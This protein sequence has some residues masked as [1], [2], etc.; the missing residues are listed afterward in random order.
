MIYKWKFKTAITAIIFCVLVIPFACE[1]QAQEPD[2][3]GQSLLPAEGEDSV[4]V[5]ETNDP[6]LNRQTYLRQIGAT[7]AWKEIN[8][9]EEIV[10]AVVDTGVD[11]D[12]PDLEGNLV[13]GINLIERDKPPHDDN[14]HGTN[15]A[16]VIA[17]VGNNGMGTSGVLWKGKIM[18]I[19]ALES[20]GRGDEEK[21]AE[22][23]RYAVDHGAKIVVLSVGLLRNDPKVEQTIR[24][25][26]ER[27]VLLI[28][29]AGND[30]GKHIRFPG[31]YPTVMAIGGVLDGNEVQERSNYG[32]ELDLVASWS[33]FTTEDG[34]KYAY[35][36]GTSMAAPQVAAAA[37]LVWGKYPEL[38][39]YEVRDLLRQTAEDLEKPGW[40]EKTGYGLL[41]VDRALTMPFQ[42][43][44][45]EPNDLPGEAK[46]FSATGR[47]ISGE[48][49][50]GAD[51]D[52]FTID[53][54]YE[55]SLEFHLNGDQKRPSQ[56]QL[57]YFNQPEGKGDGTVYAV[58]E[59]KPLKIDVQRGRQSFVL[60]FANPEEKSFWRYRLS[61][62][63]SIYA[64][65]YEDNDS[66]SKAFGL[67]PRNHTLVGTFH[68]ENDEDWFSITLD[69]PGYLELE[70]S[71]DTKRIDPIL[72]V[73]NEGGRTTWID[74]RNDGEPEK[75]SVQLMPGT[76][77]FGVS[78]TQPGAVA[79]E[80][81]LNVRFTPIYTDPNEPNDRYY[82]STV[83]S[84]G[85]EYEGVFDRPN[86]IDW[87]KF[88]LDEPNDVKL[89]VTGLPRDKQVNAVLQNSRL[90]QIATGTNENGSDRIELEKKLEPGTYYI[91]LNAVQPYNDQ[92]YKLKVEA[93]LPKAVFE[94]VA[95]HWAEEAIADLK[96]KQIVDGYESNLFRPEQ[97][98]SRAEAVAVIVRAFGLTNPKAIQYDDVPEN[99]W[100]YESIAIAAS[101]GA[102]NGYPDGSF[103]PDARITRGETAALVAQTLKL[104]G[105]TGGEKPFSDI[106]ESDWF[107]PYLAQLK[108]KGWIDGYDDGSFRPHLPI[109]RAE[110]ASLLHRILTR[111]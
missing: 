96:Q 55:G 98:I 33:V 51:Q 99:H 38:K 21:L 10:I 48:L 54:P 108:A 29:A 106:A 111:P 93:G 74:Q 67:S 23:I 22:G 35:Q 82:Q 26:E 57:V 13:P 101:A 72:K 62:S 75:Y 37:A 47:M 5:P 14:G 36:Y 19:K 4:Y 34:G 24:Y 85:T 70:L 104:P 105:E 28:A 84:F 49:H 97:A 83:I 15:V 91:S 59:G 76:V 79:G 86:D 8:S 25:A 41:R 66:A 46:L 27:D 7:E 3:S 16:G 43:D 42:P 88:T 110:F 87:Y 60:R 103:R 52:W 2:P 64:D 77:T 17:A 68:D 69:Q 32:Q 89:T 53:V 45:F 50:S 39:A 61:S 100:A 44:M 78:K 107:L 56:V 40:D 20:S 30:E 31:A 6:F 11:L 9:N 92:M 109:T 58:P 1:V 18:P 63:F 65:R 80:Y 12:H 102:V 81:T 90:E 95:G 71:V 73:Q 94:D